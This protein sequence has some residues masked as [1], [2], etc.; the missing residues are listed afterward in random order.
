MTSGRGDEAYLAA[1]GPARHVPVLRDEVMAALAPREGGLYLDATF[2]AG[3]LFEGSAR[4]AQHL[5]FSR[6]IATLP[7]LPAEPGSWPKRKGGFVL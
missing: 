6:L 7:Q 2:G 1:G 5:A 4:Q 3:R